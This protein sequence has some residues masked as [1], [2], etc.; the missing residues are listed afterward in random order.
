MDFFSDLPGGIEWI[1]IYAFGLIAIV[2]PIIAIVDVVKSRFKKPYDKAIWIIL[3]IFFNLL[4][5]ILYFTLS[6]GRKIPRH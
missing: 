4:G 2:A 1:I 3:L 5:T 6:R